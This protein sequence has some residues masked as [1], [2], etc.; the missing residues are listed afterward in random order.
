VSIKTYSLNLLLPVG[1]LNLHH[2]AVYNF[3]FFCTSP[4]A[5]KHVNG[6]ANIISRSTTGAAIGIEFIGEFVWME[7][8]INI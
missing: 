8:I 3:D 5:F 7:F 1:S 6:G 2:L 4:L